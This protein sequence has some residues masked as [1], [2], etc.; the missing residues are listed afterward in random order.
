MLGKVL[1]P[2]R[3]VPIP[4]LSGSVWKESKGLG[5]ELARIDQNSQWTVFLEFPEDSPLLARLA[6]WWSWPQRTDPK[7]TSL[8]PQ[9]RSFQLLFNCSIVSD[10]ETPWTAA[11]QASLPSLSP[12]VCSNS[13]PSSQW[14]HS[15]ISSSVIPFSSCLQSL[16]ASGSFLMSQF[17]AWGDQSVEASASASASVLPMNIQDWFPLGLTGLNSLLSKG[18]SSPAP[19][20]QSINSLELILLFVQLSHPCMTTGKTILW[21]CGPFLAKWYLCFLIQCL[22]LSK[23]FLQGASV[24]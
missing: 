20:F 3:W 21:L 6:P 15:T 1:A 10:S 5:D 18:V 13:Y 4:E 22:S 19:E 23:L 14:C 7:I 12:G 2:I 9:G 17:F 11:C 8:V 16:P 24:F